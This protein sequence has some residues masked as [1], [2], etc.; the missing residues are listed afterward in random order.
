MKLSK[1]MTE[2]PYSAIRKLT[3]YAVAAKE[4]G[5]KIYH[6]NIGAPDVRTPDEFYRAI[7]EY[8]VS[9]LTYAPSQ[10]IPELLEVTSKY[11]KGKNMDFEPE[12]LVVTAGGSESLLFCL[13]ALCDPGDEVLTCE[14]F[15]TN[16]VSYFYETGVTFNTFPTKVE[17]NF[18]LPSKEDIEKAIT[19]KTKVILLSNPGNPTGAV[20]TKE[21]LERIG[22]IAKEH[23]LFIISDE[24]YR[25]FI[26][27]GAKFVSFASI[28]GLEDRVVIIDS[29]SKRFSA[30]GARIGCVAT[31]NKDLT[32]I[33]IKLATGRLAAPTLEQV[34]AVALYQMDDS[35]FKEVNEEYQ[36]RRDCIYEELMKIDGVYA[37]K[38]AG[39]FYTMASLPVDSADDFARWMLEEFDV[40]GETVMMAPAAGFYQHEEKGKNQVRLAFVLNCEDLK[41]AMFILGEGLK[42]YQK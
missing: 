7:R 36:K 16:Y 15:Y 17:E 32:S 31:K 8:N 10:G 37:S 3:P 38:S 9:T 21:E 11:Y 35:Y 24:V 19:E 39:A 42:A 2:M 28:P 12:D 18:K 34:G 23:D 5:K 27:D 6:L 26:F 13:L 41:R 20:Y 1:R 29:I 14:P 40:D 22:E 30:C 25:E 4:K 33:F